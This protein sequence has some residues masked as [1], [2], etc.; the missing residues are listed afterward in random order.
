MLILTRRIGESI[1][2]DDNIVVTVLGITGLQTRIG[3]QAPKD[4][5]VH[6]NEI[7]ARIQEEKLKQ[8]QELEQAEENK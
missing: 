2:I 5:L 8:K 7:Y 4:I 1:N 3:V 6:R